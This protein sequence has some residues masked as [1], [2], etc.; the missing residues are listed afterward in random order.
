MTVRDTSRIG[1]GLDICFGHMLA[2]SVSCGEDRGQKHSFGA[3]MCCLGTGI[4]FTYHDL[5]V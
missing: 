1:S 2:V 5:D 4:E 3:A